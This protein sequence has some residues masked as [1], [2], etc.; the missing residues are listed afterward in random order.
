MFKAHC[1]NMQEQ[2]SD[3]KFENR[4]LGSDILK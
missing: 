1:K 4:P 2:R 3:L